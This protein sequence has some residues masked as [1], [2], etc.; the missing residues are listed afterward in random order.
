MK[1]YISNSIPFI[2]NNVITVLD[3]NIYKVYSYNTLI[4]SSDGYFNSTYYSSTTSRVQ[5]IVKEVRKV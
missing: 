5:N 4:Y 1:G 3:N 2:G